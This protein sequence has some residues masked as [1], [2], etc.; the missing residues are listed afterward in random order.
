MIK[1]RMVDRT[2]ASNLRVSMFTDMMALPIKL[3]ETARC[4][5]C[6]EAKTA[7]AKRTL[8]KCWRGHHRRGRANERN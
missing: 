1:E 5:N 6:R 8:S 2:V 7:D 4:Q 3:T